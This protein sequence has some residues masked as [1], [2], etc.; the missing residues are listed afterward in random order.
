MSSFV[1]T[2][3]A[4]DFSERGQEEIAEE[5]FSII[6]KQ[7]AAG[8]SASGAPYPPGVTKN[9]LNMIDTRNMI[10]I[11]RDY[12]SFFTQNAE[13]PIAE[14]TLQYNAEYAIYTQAKYNWAGISSAYFVDFEK[15]IQPIIAR[16]TSG[17]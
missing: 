1:V 3:I 5:A 7:T 2:P 12:T 15:A 11:D 9:P 17:S 16:E 13:D 10:F 14:I 6:A 8:F 4:F